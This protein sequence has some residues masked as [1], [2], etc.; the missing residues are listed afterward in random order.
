MTGLLFDVDGVLLDS[1]A[2]YIRVWRRWADVRGLDPELV[3]SLTHGRR[4]IDTV[5]EVAPH[6]DYVDERTLFKGL[7]EVELPNIT[8][9]PGAAELLA[10]LPA[11]GW[12]CVTSAGR[13]WVAAR[14]DDA[15]LPLPGALV[16]AEDVDRGKPDPACY[17]LG[18]QR[19][20][21]PPADCWVVEDAAAGIQAGH[22]AGMQVVGLATTH[23][24]DEIADADYVFDS[25][26]EATP[27][28]LTRA[29]ALT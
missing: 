25:L 17:L 12:G 18:A 20:D 27:F 26:A 4:A 8:S 19:L 10:R 21:R 2:A 11:G 6:I 29:G 7:F 23:S 9:M 15:G 28:L 5:R 14:F 3:V 13:N 24:R 1:T 16:T 22:A